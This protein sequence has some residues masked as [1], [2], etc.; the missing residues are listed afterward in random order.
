MD[1]LINFYVIDC[2]EEFRHTNGSDDP[3]RIGS[4][5]WTRVHF[6]EEIDR[7]YGISIYG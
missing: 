1:Y 7:D 6:R 5:G 4:G 2:P 3:R